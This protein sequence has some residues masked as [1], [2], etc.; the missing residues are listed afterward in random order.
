MGGNVYFIKSKTMSTVVIDRS[1][2]F[3]LIQW[4]VWLVFAPLNRNAKYLFHIEINNKNSL[5]LLIFAVRCKAKMSQMNSDFIGSHD[6]FDESHLYT[7]NINTQTQAN[8]IVQSIRFVKIV[9]KVLCR[10]N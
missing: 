7:I 5:S 8:T 3:Q 1:I 10:S 6:S 9:E 4:L 2:R